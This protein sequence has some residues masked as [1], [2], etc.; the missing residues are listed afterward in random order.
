MGITVTEKKVSIKRK[1]KVLFT[2]LCLTVCNLMD[3]MYPTR[4]LCPWDSPGRN[5]G[6]GC[7]SLLQG[8]FLTLG[9][10]LGLLH[11]RQI[12][13]HWATRKAWHVGRI[14]VNYCKSVWDWTCAIRI[15]T[16]VGVGPCWGL[17]LF[18]T[19]STSRVLCGNLRCMPKSL[20]L[21]Q[22]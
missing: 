7:H 20:S 11:C 4:L 3:C 16:F 6:V 18:V 21:G 9:S 2:Q 10:N 22:L 5:T 19:C 12:I 13:Y 17:Y 8:I 1:V 15:K 14:G